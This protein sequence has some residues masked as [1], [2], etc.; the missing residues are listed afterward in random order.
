MYFSLAIELVRKSACFQA[1]EA[2]ISGGTDIEE[3]IGDFEIDYFERKQ[4]AKL[5]S[6]PGENSKSSLRKGVAGGGCRL[7]RPLL[8]VLVSFLC[9]H[10]ASFRRSFVRMSCYPFAL[11]NHHHY[12]HSTSLFASFFRS[13][14]DLNSLSSTASRLLWTRSILVPT[15]ISQTIHLDGTSWM[16]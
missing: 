2:A 12:R 10:L 13:V 11:A 15:S 6:R 5:P 9:C 8:R 16:S 4:R 3:G 7:T 1:R 14:L